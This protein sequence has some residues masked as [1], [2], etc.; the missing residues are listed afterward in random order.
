GPAARRR[1]PALA[2]ERMGRKGAEHLELTLFREERQLLQRQLQAALLGMALD[3]GIELRLLE[4]RA[5]EIALELDDVDAVGGEAAER[6]VERR[7]HALHP[8]QERRHAA[9]RAMVEPG[10]VAREHQHAGGVVV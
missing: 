6:L 2:A 7:R 3:L 1:V 10:L 4:M 8:E 5:A 9:H